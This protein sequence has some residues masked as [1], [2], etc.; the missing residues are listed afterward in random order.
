M[1][2]NSANGVAPIFIEKPSTKSDPESKRLC[3]ECKIKADPEPKITWFR[4]DIEVVDKGSCTFFFS[5][6]FLSFHI[7]DKQILPLGRHLI[8][9]DK[10]S[11]NMYFA[12]L[13]IDDVNGD[14]AG[15][16]R[17]NAKNNC[18]ETN[19]TINLTFDGMQN[20]F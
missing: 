9:C 7:A 2:L 18:G 20:L 11:D 15:K 3:F 13:E 16:Y 17:V 19:G 14:D 5:T 6:F 8:Y 1:C 12:C 10:L 4:N